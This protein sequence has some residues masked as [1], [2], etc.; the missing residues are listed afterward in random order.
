MCS[1]N[2]D[3]QKAIADIEQLFEVD[4]A[5][6]CKATDHF[7]KCMDAGLTNEVPNRVYM[8]MLP[9]FVTSIPTGKENGL[10]LAV[11]LG[12][13]N[14]RVCSIDLKGD[15]TFELKQS[16][17]PVPI[18]LMRGSTSDL[19]FSFFAEKVKNFL[20]EHH[21]ELD[22]SITLKMGFTFSFPVDQTAI[23]SGKLI[24]WTKGFDLPDCI[25]CDVVKYFQKHLDLLNLPV[26]IT[27]LANDTVGTLLS[28]AYTNDRSASKSRTLIGAIFGTGTNGAYFESI[29]NIPKLCGT[30][31]PEL[32]TGMVINTEWGSF[33]N[34]LDILPSTKYDEL[35]DQ[36]TSNKGYHLFEKRISGM[37]LGEILRVILIDLFERGLIFVELFRSRNGS[38]PHRLTE[39]FLLS[40]KVLSYLEIDDST[41]LHMSELLLQNELRLPTTY[42]ERLLIQSVTRAISR[43]AAY[44]S[45]IPLAAIVKRVK[46]QY[47]DEDDDFEVGCDGSL[48]EHYPGFRDKILEAFNTINPLEGC[49]KKLHIRIAKDGSG[50][51][52]ALCASTV[53]KS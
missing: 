30:S 13:T 46:G 28:R 47:S 20:E 36:N 53:G 19:L 40:S 10:F 31:F 38:L 3:L 49:S 24:R 39:P 33:D 7:V 50:V 25:G 37:F 18:D 4:K 52:A 17:F 8:P 12:G 42:S 34:S 23:D 6:L 45:A 51:G 15:H 32:A 29:S 22:E 1:L 9:T 35:V 41:D 11:D 26:M 48:I 44:L 43:R 5:F 14:F 16:K 21:E 2:T 27:A